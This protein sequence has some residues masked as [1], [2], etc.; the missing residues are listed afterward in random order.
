M[1]IKATEEQLNK[2]FNLT[3]YQF[4]IP[5]YQRPYAWTEDQV[6]EL[7]DDLCD[8]FPYP[9]PQDNPY[10]FFGSIILIKEQAKPNAE[11]IDGQ[12]RLT[13]LTLLLS[14]FRHLLPLHHETREMINLL[15][16]GKDKT[17][18]NKQYGLQLKIQDNEFFGEYIRT[19]GGIKNLL[20]KNAGLLTDSQRLLRDN[21]KVLVKELTHCRP[22]N[23]SLEEWILH[24][25]TSLLD[26][27]YLVVVSTSDFDTAYRIFSTI[28]SRG[29][30]LELNDILKSEIIGKIK[31]D[32]K[33]EKY[34]QIWEN[35][36]K[37]L[38][39]ED[40]KELFSHI[41]R[42]QK[43]ERPKET[44]LSEYRKKIKPQDNPTQFIDEILKPCSDIFEIIRDQ[45]FS[46]D[47]KEDEQEINRL[48]GWLNLINN[49]DWLPPAISF[50]VKY[51]NK[52]SLIKEFFINLE[53]LAI[54]LMIIRADI[55]ER[56]RRYAQIL[57]AIDDAGVKSAIVK[58]EE[59]LYLEEQN[60][61]I[62]ILDG[63]LYQQTRTCLYVLKRL[64][65]AI[66]EGNLS[67]SFNAKL[68]TIEHVLPQNPKADSDWS[69]TWD[70]KAREKWVHRLGNLV[71][72][73][74]KKNSLAKNYDFD[75]KKNQY[76]K[77]GNKTIYPLTINVIHQD[78]WTVKQVEINQEKYLGNL[79]KI[80]NLKRS[81]SAKI[82][83]HNIDHNDEDWWWSYLKAHNIITAN[84][85]GKV[86]DQGEKI[87]TSYRKGDIIIAYANSYGAIGWG[88]IKE[89]PTY[90]L[91]EIGSDEDVR[92]G[93][94][95]HRLN[96]DWQC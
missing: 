74:R 64:D 56:G 27:C 78:K 60:K 1:S 34:T 30:D 22:E 40:F 21:A 55:N 15:L 96:I 69:K 93:K 4:Q 24:L 49:S 89:Y 20:E 48:F 13:T 83:W 11:V 7:I 76:F 50:L 52:A 79:I 58:A 82:Y 12:Q 84:F 70:D 5:S 17:G 31:G 8:A 14:V 92:N 53:R 45:R 68:V 46:C 39:R 43:R 18:K 65:S 91:I 86:G 67:P 10:Y 36:E 33:K 29:L 54:G 42:I 19:T 63:D 35:E 16:E 94:H 6:L 32:T 77:K 23:L 2:I 80:W 3:N 66:A 61:I 38:G 9:L 75:Q 37:D 90:R 28:N 71:L 88:I 44:L 41:Y 25:Y 62:E 95:L 47:N 51:S 87:L 57:K 72:L 85:E 26:N 59:L 73:S 81:N